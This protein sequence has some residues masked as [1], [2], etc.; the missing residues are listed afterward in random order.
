MDKEAEEIM[1]EIVQSL[2]TVT[3]A[4]REYWRLSLDERLRLP[5]SM[6]VRFDSSSE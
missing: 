2:A 4:E 1:E 5:Q 3:D 6:R